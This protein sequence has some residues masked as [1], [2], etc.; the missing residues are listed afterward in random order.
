MKPTETRNEVISRI[1]GTVRVI[2]ESFED[3]WGMSPYPQ[4]DRNDGISNHSFRTFMRQHNSM[5]FNYFKK[6][7][8]K[9]A[10]TPE[11]QAAV[12]QQN[13]ETMMIKKMYQVATMAQREGKSKVP[14]AINEVRED[15]SLAEMENE[16][17]GVAAFN[18]KGAQPKS[19]YSKNAQQNCGYPSN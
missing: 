15:D 14:A 1:T 10:L 12:A 13:P 4:N 8:F 18:Q 16:D 17:N 19:G 6:N 5:M 9:A 7:L 2:K 3:Y 11:L